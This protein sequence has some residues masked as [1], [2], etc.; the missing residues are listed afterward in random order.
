MKNL[1]TIIL[2]A[3]KGTRMKSALPKVLHPVCGKPIIQYILDVAK[4]VGSLK[5]YVVL[6]HKARD[7]QAILPSDTQVVEQKQLLG[8]GD[9][10]KTCANSFKSYTG[11]V[12]ILC[13][14]TPMLTKQTVKAIVGKHKRSKADGTFLTTVVHDPDGYG[15]IIR[16]QNNRV[17]AIREDKDAS[18][19]ERDIAEINVGVYCFKASLLFKTLSQVKMNAKKKEYYLTDIIELMANQGAH[20][21]TIATDDPRE[22]LGINSRTDLAVAESIIRGRILKEFM[23]AGVTIEDPNTTYI[24]ADAK[25][26]QD[27]I[28]K[29]FTYIEENVSIGKSCV[30]GPFARIRPNSNIGNKAEIG[31]F[32]EVSRTKMG[33]HCF[34]KHFSY[35][36]DATLGSKVNIGAGVVTANF[37]GKDKHLTKISDGAFVGS[38]AIL[39]APVHVGKKAIVGAGSVVVKKNIPEGATAVGVPATLT[40]GKKRS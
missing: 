28:I 17:L 19:F 37:D 30:I 8:T 34:M 9:A 4:V 33:D 16:D 1:R 18:G 6:G 12:L 25:I 14:D 20:L 38:D 40:K 26:G 36:G 11:D 32:T 15:R 22:G 31:N 39:V 2:A 13:G 24:H 3:G 5:T 21:E 27:T 23:N 29:P 35:L 10:V 7:V